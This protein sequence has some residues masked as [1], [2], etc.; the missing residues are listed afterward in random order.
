MSTADCPALD[1]DLS[2]DMGIFDFACQNTEWVLY[3]L[4]SLLPRDQYNTCKNNSFSDS[5][6][7]LR[8]VCW[9]LTSAVTR[10]DLWKP[11]ISWTWKTSPWFPTILLPPLFMG[12][13]LIKSRSNWSDNEAV[14]KRRVAPFCPLSVLTGEFCRLVIITSSYMLHRS[15]F[16]V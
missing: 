6:P 8:N 15:M 5:V 9:R 11:W 12:E 2:L 13:Q 16:C 1:Y 3:S 4:Y 14:S 7:L 10:T